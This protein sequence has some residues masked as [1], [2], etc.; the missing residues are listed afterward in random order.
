[1]TPAT[2][3][4]RPPI[5][6]IG[7]GPAGLGAA[8]TLAH[9]GERICLVERDTQAGGLCRSLRRGALTVDLGAHYLSTELPEVRG[10]IAALL[11]DEVLRLR[12]LTGFFWRGRHHA[13]PPRL[14]ELARHLPPG[15][16]AGF[17]TGLVRAR[18]APGDADS[19]AATLRAHYGAPLYDAFFAPYLRKV[20]GMDADE[21]DPGTQSG[22]ADGSFGLWLAA[23]WRAL[24]HGAD[25]GRHDAEVFYPPDGIGSFYEAI[26]GWLRAQGHELRMGREV[27][28]IEHADGRITGLR[29]RAADG[30]ESHL[31]CRG[32]LSSMPLRLLATRLSPALPAPL[33]A[34]A[35]ALRM[36]STV[37]VYLVQRDTRPFPEH[38]VYVTDAG[39]GMTRLT[40][41]TNWSPRLMPGPGLTCL[42]CEYWCD[43]GDA[44]WTADEAALVTLAREEL[45]AMGL[46]DDAPPIDSFVVRLAGTHPVLDRAGRAARERLGAALDGFGNLVVTGRGGAFG[47]LDQDRAL[48][49]GIEAARRLLAKPAAGGMA[50]PAPARDGPVPGDQP[51]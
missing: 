40:N 38:S 2:T 39:L 37:L 3:D 14:P 36:R 4:D 9:A 18:L 42:C 28:A 25:A 33:L 26:A 19:H 17:V 23:R 34:D 31:P 35:G 45:A 27:V 51:S 6:V 43:A 44:V 24:M 49:D 7:A 48:V 30:E 10:L 41:F 20:W 21:L 32:L 46:A 5:V 1:M 8:W 15:E 22:R 29:L 16:L 11:G 47:H 12:R 50:P 13:Y